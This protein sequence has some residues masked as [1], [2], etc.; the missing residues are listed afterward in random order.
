M[1]ARDIFGTDSAFVTY[2][3]QIQIR[4]IL[5][6]GVP[7]D[8]SVIRRWL[9]ARLE[10]GDKRLNEILRQTVAERNVT[11]TVDAQLDELMKSD[12][13]PSVNG[14]KRLPDGELSYEGRCL[15]GAFKEWANSSYPCLDW[16]GKFLTGKTADTAA[17]EAPKARKPARK[18]AF[19]V[20]PQKGLLSTASERVF[21]DPRLIGLGVKEPSRIEE[22]I[23]RVRL[24]D[25]R[26]ASA[27][28]RVEVVD[29]PL[30]T[31]EVKIRDNF[32]TDTALS[33]IWQ[34]GEEIGLGADRARSD[35][36][37]DLVSWKR[38]D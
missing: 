27:I 26:P 19:G 36:R 25:G 9:E 6:G 38:I 11:L 1:S 14:F 7:S 13:A 8:P 12:A 18:A 23:K 10:V 20:A 35:G 21:F 15:K 22:R 31:F 33:R 17:E 3:A 29:R 28:S 2:E 37:F 32:L 16:D 30:L 24:P 5:V 4:D 34:T